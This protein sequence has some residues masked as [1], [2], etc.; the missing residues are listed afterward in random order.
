MFPVAFGELLASGLKAAPVRNL[1]RTLNRLAQ[2][3]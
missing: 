2:T 1:G 3:P